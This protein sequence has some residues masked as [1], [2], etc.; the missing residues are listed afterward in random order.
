VGR[1]AEGRDID[2]TRFD[3]VLF[4]LEGV[5]VDSDALLVSVWRQAFDEFQAARL[6]TA[7]TMDPGLRQNEAQTS[8]AAAATPTAPFDAARDYPMQIRGY[9]FDLVAGRLLA[10]RQITVPPG[11]ARDRP[12]A[13]STWGLARRAERILAARLR[14]GV[15]VRDAAVRLAKTLHRCGFRVGLVSREAQATAL[16]QAAGLLGLF[17]ARV[18]GRDVQRFRL[19][20][21]PAPEPWRD[22][23][24]RLEVPVRRSAALVSGPAEAAAARQAGIAAVWNVGDR[25]ALGGAPDVIDAFTV[26]LPSAPARGA[27][28]APLPSALEHM[29]AVVP[30]GGPVALF[31]D[32][33]GTLTGITGTPGEAM[34][35]DYVR[36]MLAAIARC[37]PVAIVSGR[38]RENLQARVQL[39]M[40]YYAGSHG[41]DIAGPDGLRYEHPDALACVASLD[42][43]ET[44]LHG[45]L[46]RVPGALVERKRFALATHYRKVEPAAVP[47]VEE[48]V[49]A[50][51]AA[52]PDLRPS[53]GKKVIELLPAVDWHKG[54]AVDWLLA[55]M[56]PAAWPIY[57][58]DDQTDEEALALLKER[59]SGIVVQDTPA[60]TAARYRLASPDEVAKFLALL[61]ARLG[62]AQS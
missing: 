3:A 58:G 34:L 55:R 43:A 1:S 6:A 54:R 47:R 4:L 53:R 14:A 30:A 11:G 9:P 16:L 52:H 38:D 19:G 36:D 35:A 22:A 7:T 15:A 45:R 10:A 33:D 18:D 46:D 57:V 25:A 29:D 41:F 44:Y 61:A 50:V 59:G 42:A 40:L 8:H 28:A 24:R 51:L 32:F 20:P 17:D 48:A 5:L 2:R 62:E 60:A 37:I 39:P 49:A 12:E 56:G 26:V 31:L 13:L 21:W 27:A 23:L